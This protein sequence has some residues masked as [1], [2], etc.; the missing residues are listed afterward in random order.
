M[1]FGARSGSSVLTWG[2]C[3]LEKRMNAFAARGLD[4]FFGLVVAST[5]DAFASAASKS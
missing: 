4:V 5:M 1:S 3:S 2:R